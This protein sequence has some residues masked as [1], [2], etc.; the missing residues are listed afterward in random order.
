MWHPACT[1][2][3]GYQTAVGVR[4]GSNDPMLTLCST[5]EGGCMKKQVITL[6]GVLSLVL[7][8]GSAFAQTVSIRGKIP[9]DFMVGKT[10]LPS[11]TYEIRSLNGWSRQD[12]AIT[13]NR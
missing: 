11:G 7:V 3:N 8:T 12:V 1:S 5:H 13:R 9:F 4:N 2:D 6:I 10:T